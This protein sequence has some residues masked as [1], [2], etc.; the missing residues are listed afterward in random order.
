MKE[1]HWFDRT[2]EFNFPVEA[3]PNIVERVRGTPA[4]LEEMVRALP[5]GILTMQQGD[6]WSV[7]EHV[8]HLHD[9]DELHEGRLAD[10]NANLDTLRPAD[11]TNRKTHEA[12]HNA[13]SIED[14]LDAFRAARMSFV[15]QLDAMDL[16]MAGRTALHPRLQKQ[17]RVVDLA[18]F[19]AEH[20]DHHLA[21]ITR[22]GKAMRNT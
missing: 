15:A 14:L 1:L 19:V 7:Q 3:F 10:Y 12:D 22:L 9:L 20:D 11:L 6:A 18:Y 2:F 5:P 17:M 16:D 13:A 8:G 21:E 4:R